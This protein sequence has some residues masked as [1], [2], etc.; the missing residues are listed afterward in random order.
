M[1][2]NSYKNKYWPEDMADG[3]ADKSMEMRWPKD[4]A[5]F[6]YWAGRIND[7]TPLEMVEAEAQH[8]REVLGTP[9]IASTIVYLIGHT[10]RLDNGEFVYLPAEC[11]KNGPQRPMG[12]PYSE[13]RDLILK[14]P[15]PAPLLFVGDF[16]NCINILRLPYVLCHD[17]ANSSWKEVE[18]CTPS[19]WPSNK[20][21]L[22]FAATSVD[23]LAH[24]FESSGGIFTRQFC[25]ISPRQSITLGERSRLIQGWMDAFFNDYEVLNPG[26]RLAQQHQVYSSH[27]QDL[28]DTRLFRHMGFC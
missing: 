22:H 4:F 7:G 6:K 5:T 23:Q 18:G 24:E 28:N 17:G 21:V 12:I 1:L 2:G 20:V 3:E 25:N 8:I 27:K 10:M 14:D 15:N 9:R 19:S 26:K 13:M 11:F 16:C